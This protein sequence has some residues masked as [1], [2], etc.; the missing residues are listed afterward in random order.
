M[1]LAHVQ[2]A[3]IMEDGK[4]LGGLMR[5][6]NPMLDLVNASENKVDTVNT[7]MEYNSRLGQK[8]K[9]E[10]LLEDVRTP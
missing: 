6:A 5:V 7:M 2:W 3:K 9:N 4:G 1:N 10:F 8:E